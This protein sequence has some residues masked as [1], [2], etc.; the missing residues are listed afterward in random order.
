MTHVDD[1]LMISNCKELIMDTYEKLL[2]VYKKMTFDAEAT[3]FI[4]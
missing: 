1:L 3:E 4:G 2:G